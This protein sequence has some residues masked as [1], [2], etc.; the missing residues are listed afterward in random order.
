MNP[1]EEGYR[2]KSKRRGSEIE[3]MDREGN[4]RDQ[5]RE[6]GTRRDT[7]HTLRGDT[8]PDQRSNRQSWIQ[9]ESPLRTQRDQEEETPSEDQEDTYRE[10][11]ETGQLQTF[12]LSTRVNKLPPPVEIHRF[13]GDQVKKTRSPGSDNIRSPSGNGACT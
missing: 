10:N 13:H 7:Q 8:V 12:R 6:I 2:M 5:E 9:S 11:L 4:R 3:E 1:D